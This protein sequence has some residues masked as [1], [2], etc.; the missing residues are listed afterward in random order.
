MKRI[1]IAAVGLPLLCCSPAFAQIDDPFTATTPLGATSPLGIGPEGSVGAAG[2]PLDATELMS[3]GVSPAPTTSVTGT[4]AI[5]STGA[6]T[7]GGTTCSAPGVLPSGMYGSTATYDGGGTAA[8][9]AAPATAATTDPTATPG[10]ST[11]SQ[12][13]V[14]SAPAGISTASGMLDTSGM[15]GMCGSGSSSLASSSTPTSTAPTT[16]G[17]FAR[18]GIPFDSTEISS[19]GVS[20]APAVPITGVLP[21]VGSVGA[22]SLASTMPTTAPA[23]PMAP[24]PI[25]NAASG[26]FSGN[27]LAPPSS[28]INP[29]G[30]TLTSRIFGR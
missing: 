5:P 7:S 18:T 14:P 10:T 12:M 27:T 30:S 6:I 22:P 13:S 19:L 3:L 25:A 28:T 26:N 21:I 1:W 4:I 20:S 11:S 8:G 16:P 17:G 15:S 23:L 9:A 29:S 24:P 2:I